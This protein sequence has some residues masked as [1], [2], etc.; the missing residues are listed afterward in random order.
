MD[1]PRRALSLSHEA[2]NRAARFALHDLLFKSS[3]SNQN[4]QAVGYQ[5]TLHR[6]FS[7]LAAVDELV[8][9][10]VETKKREGQVLQLIQ[11]HGI[12]MECIPS[13]KRT[14]EVYELMPDNYG[15]T[16]LIRNLGN[17]TLAGVL[18]TGHWEAIKKVINWLI[19]KEQLQRGRVHP[20][21]SMVWV[22]GCVET[23]HGSLLP[24]SLKHWKQPTACPL[25]YAALATTKTTQHLAECKAAVSPRKSGNSTERYSRICLAGL[26]YDEHP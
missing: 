11:D 12:T 24:I 23:A 18:G 15:I 4:E 19:S 10:L 6:A 5:D 13:K 17:L 9:L 22:V 20:R 3:K 16:A 26:P 2:K 21:A 25:S 8:S 7:F 14:K 1:T